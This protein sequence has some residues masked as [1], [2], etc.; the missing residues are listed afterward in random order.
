MS[1]SV[2]L[3]K[4]S[5]DELLLSEPETRVILKFFWPDESTRIE[6]LIINDSVRAFAQGL[7]IE[8][9]DATYQ[10]GFIEAVFRSATNPT[11]GAIKVIKGFAQARIQ[12]LV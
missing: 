11:R 1:N 8:A 10:V 6:S 3:R 9:I 7:L 5:S 2:H 4:F 12:A